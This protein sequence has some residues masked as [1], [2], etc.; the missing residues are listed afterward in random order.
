MQSDTIAVLL[1]CVYLLC[2]KLVMHMVTIVT[3]HIFVAPV[4]A[5]GNVVAPTLWICFNQ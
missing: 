5:Q 4:S 1:F 3:V 2:V